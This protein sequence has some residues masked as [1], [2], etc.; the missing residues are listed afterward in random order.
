MEWKQKIVFDKHIGEKHYLA[1]LNEQKIID[2]IYSYKNGISQNL[3]SKKYNVSRRT[4]Q[5]VL[6]GKTWK[7]I[8]QKLL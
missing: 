7:K 8:T 2:I 5:D 3:L 4:I 6:Q 1:K